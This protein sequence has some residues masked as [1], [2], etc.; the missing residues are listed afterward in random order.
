MKQ[1]LAVLMVLALIAGTSFAVDIGGSTA[2]SGMRGEKYQKIC[3]DQEVDIDID[4]F[5]IDLDGGY[6]IDL[7]LDEKVWDYGLGASY[8]LAYF[9]FGSIISGEKDLE[10]NE[11]KSYVDFVYETI[12]FNVTTLFSFD[13]EKDSFQGAEFSAFG[14]YGPA[15]ITLGYLFTDDGAEV[16][17]DAPDEPLNGGFYAKAK[18]SY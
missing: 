13:E 7:E 9:T 1:L 16:S 6:D 18:L 11:N 3:I 5:H 4:A 2:A 12:G 15:E 14:S 17:G 10:L 8:T